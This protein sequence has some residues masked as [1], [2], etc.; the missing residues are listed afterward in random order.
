MA[1]RSRPSGV[2]DARFWRHFRKSMKSQGLQKFCEPNLELVLEAGPSEPAYRWDLDGNLEEPD[3]VEQL[4]SFWLTES[5]MWLTDDPEEGIKDLRG[6]ITRLQGHMKNGDTAEA[7]LHA[8]HLG[9]TLA[10]WTFLAELGTDGR[11]RQSER[12][13]AS[14][15]NMDNRDERAAKAREIYAVLC[16]KHAAKWRPG[17]GRRKLSKE[18]AAPDV[19]KLLAAQAVFVGRDAILRYLQ[20]YDPN[21]PQTK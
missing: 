7:A 8:C 3:T 14:D 15:A 1:K 11:R 13:R 10:T 16:Q 2:P 5:R 20:G 12:R 19:E 4:I 17:R 9:L 6:R 18:A 21:P